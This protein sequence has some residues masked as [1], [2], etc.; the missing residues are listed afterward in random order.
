LALTLGAIEESVATRA[1]RQIAEQVVADLQ[2]AGP[3]WTG[4]FRNA[5]RINAGDT[6]VAATVDRIGGYQ[7]DP[8]DSQPDPVAARRITVPALGFG[9][10]FK[11]S[12]SKQ[13]TLY[14]IGNAAKYRLLAMDLVPGRNPP[15]TAPQDWFLTYMDGGAFT[16]TVQVRLDRAIQEAAGMARM[17]R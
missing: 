13:K 10:R 6:P 3:V 4:T 16:R 9:P 5:W 2:K 8:D 12:L 15:R 1:P 7:Y 14:T 17:Y 11:A